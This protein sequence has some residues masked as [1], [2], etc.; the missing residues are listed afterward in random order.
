MASLRS[1]LG[2]AWRRLSGR[3]AA[4][5]RRIDIPNAH[6]ADG[7]DR[8]IAM[9]RR[10]TLGGPYVPPKRKEGPDRRKGDEVLYF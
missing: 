9:T 6:Q 8:H 5:G 4:H 10:L 1:A 3:A 7:D 2:A